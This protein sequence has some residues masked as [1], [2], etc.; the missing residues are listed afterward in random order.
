MI[1]EESLLKYRRFLKRRNYSAHTIKTYLNT[2]EHFRR[3]LPLPWEEVTYQ[4]IS[5]YI[6]FLL[7]QGL[8]PKTINCRLD[9]VRGYYHYRNQEAGTQMPNPVKRGLAL[10]LPRPLPRFLK[11]EEVR[12][13]SVP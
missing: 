2:L 5:A 4:E 6:D 8:T 3:W 13:S 1:P 9:S 12:S 11:D 7:A 10:R